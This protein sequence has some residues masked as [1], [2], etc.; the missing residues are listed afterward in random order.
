MDESC[1]QKALDYLYS[2]VDHSMTRALRYSPEKFNLDRMVN[3]ARISGNPQSAYPTVHI[4]GTKGK[5]STAAMIASC[6]MAAGYRVGLYTSPHLTEY[7]ERIQVNGVEISQ[8]D[9]AAMVDWLRPYAAQV[10]EITT[11]ELTTMLGFKFFELQ[12]VD[13]AV[14]EVGLGGRLDATNIIDPLVSVI[15]SLSLDHVNVLGDTL[16]KIA[17]EKAGIVKSGKPVVLSPQLENARKVVEQVCN[18]RNARLFQVGSDFTGS[19]IST[20]LTSQEILLK[21]T[22]LSG[23]PRYQKKGLHV[24]LPLLGSHQLSNAVTAFGALQ[25]IGEHGFKVNSQQFRRGFSTV[26][27]PGRFE[28]L[29]ESPPIIVDSAHNPDSAQKLRKT[30]DD[31]LPG[32][33]IVLIFGASEDKDVEGMF[34]SLLPGVRLVIATQSTHPRALET[35]KIVAIAEQLHT[36]AIIVSEV[37]QAL[38]KAMELAGSGDVIVVTGSLFI[39]AAVRDYWNS[40]RQHSVDIRDPQQRE[41]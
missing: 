23:F 34:K 22:A 2:F 6:L 25:I 9:L 7:T 8:D 12:H 24:R 10:P 13:I 36:P 21:N 27:W 5:G 38:D 17:F 40:G 29:Q 39:A 28:I 19:I 41:K 35:E 33:G 3:L 18:E 15:T 1:Y 14:I 20:S 16:E 37:T 11:F 31:Y 30:I 4:A 32:K 26:H